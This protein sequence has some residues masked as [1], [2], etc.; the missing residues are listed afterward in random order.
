MK[1]HILIIDDDEDE[2]K[3]L[4]GA[5]QQL[6]IPHK[7][8][9]AKNGWQALQQLQYITP[10]IILL[11]VNMPYMNGL[12]CLDGIKK[13]PHCSQIPVILQS[14]EMDNKITEQGMQAGAHACISKAASFTEL[15]IILSGLLEE[16]YLVHHK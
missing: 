2:L 7:C 1:K 5:L 11:D 8:T 14:T 9:W 16:K 4:S 6:N 3:I 13:L 10:D 15:K 12:Q